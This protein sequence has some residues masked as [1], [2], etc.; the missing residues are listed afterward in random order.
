MS[1]K[2]KWI[3]TVI[4]ALTDFESPA[5]RSLLNMIILGV[6]SEYKKGTYTGKSGIEILNCMGIDNKHIEYKGD[7]E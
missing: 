1:K 4:R 7:F 6:I 5:E 3:D 2:D